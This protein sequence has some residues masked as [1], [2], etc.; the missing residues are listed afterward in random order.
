MAMAA[1]VAG[2]ASADD[3]D[4]DDESY[5]LGYPSIIDDVEY[6]DVRESSDKDGE[7]YVE[8]VDLDG[9]IAEY[10]IICYY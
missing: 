2:P 1:L 10:E 4:L 5:F 8:D 6:E 7:C 3:I 9:Y